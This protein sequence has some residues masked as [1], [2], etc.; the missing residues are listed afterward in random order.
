MRAASY[1]RVSSEEQVEGYSI[2]AQL[3]ACRSYAEGA[4][5]TVVAEYVD[6]GKSAR[7]EDISK[8]P[9]FK[10]ML[11]AAKNREFDILIVHKL[12][13][14]SRNLLL[15]LR[16][17]DELSRTGTTFISV[18]EQIDYT[19]PMGR[20]FLAMSGAFAQFYSD[21]LSQ[22]TKKGWHERREQGLYCGT[23]PFGA[24]KGEDGVPIPDTL[25]R[26]GTNG[27][28][29]SLI[30][31]EGLKMAFDLAAEGKSDRE[32]V[33]ALNDR[34]YRT[35]GTHDPKPFSRDTVK[36]MLT[37]RFYVGFIPDGDDGWIKA[38]HEPLIEPEVF[39]EAQN[40]R[41]RNRKST[42]THSPVGKAV[43]SLTGITFCW[44]CR[45]KDRE[46]RMHISYSS[47][48]KRRMGCYNRA[49]G[50]DCLQKS[51]PLEVYEQQ[52]RAYLETFHIPEDYQRKILDMQ[53][54]LHQNYDVDKEQRQLRA[55]LDRIKELYKWGDIS[56]ERYLAEKGQIQSDL[57]KLVPF[58]TPSDKLERLAEFIANIVKA[59]DVATQEQKN[60]LARTLLQEVWVKDGDVVAV[61]P[62]PDF[63]PFFKLNWEEFSRRIIN[64]RPRGDL[65]P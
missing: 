8:R 24:M 10:A 56:K 11:E 26:N 30:N 45:E 9:R 33:I 41:E 49:K 64:W 36:H 43:Y 65:N 42:H 7:A 21:N 34:G 52:I 2:D 50:W 54:Q 62:Q 3:R 4:G 25:E 13:R 28:R 29:H 23:L 59:W 31:Y 58:Q 6:E 12:D 63:G 17:F 32:I 35:T 37:N 22:E 14:F 38:K 48:G 16:C 55:R 19:T 20:V 46:G 61:K 53:K 1:A 51:A 60:M 18:S 39:E 57:T 44:Y 5:W 47:G 27:R 15:T 40:T